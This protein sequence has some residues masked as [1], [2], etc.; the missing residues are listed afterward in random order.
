MEEFED[1]ELPPLIPWNL[2]ISENLELTRIRE[3][4]LYLRLTHKEDNE[5]VFIRSDEVEALIEKLQEALDAW[6]GADNVG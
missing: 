2:E 1:I 4:I 6:S 3:D 5:G